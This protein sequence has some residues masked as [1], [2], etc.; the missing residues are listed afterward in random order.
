MNGCY[1]HWSTWTPRKDEKLLCEREENN[2]YGIFAIKVTDSR[3]WWA[4]CKRKLLNYFL[5]L[6]WANLNYIVNDE[7]YYRYPIVQG[8]LEILC[9]LPVR[10]VPTSHNRSIAVHF[11]MSLSIF[12]VEPTDEMLMGSVEQKESKKKVGQFMSCSTDAWSF[13][14]KN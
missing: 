8:G 14:K 4:T 2:P 13:Y 11:E 1:Y 10:M 12:N 3:G 5:I 6:R 9:K 7:S